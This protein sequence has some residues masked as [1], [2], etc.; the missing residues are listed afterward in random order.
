MYPKNAAS[1]ER[2]AVGA[3]YL[4]ADG[5]IQTTGASVRVMP[6]GGAAGAGTGTLD[7]DATSG[8]W[9]Y[10]PAQSETNYTSFMV[11]VYKASCTSACAT[12]VTTASTTPGTTRVD[13]IT[14]DA[15]TAASINT[16][17]LTADAFADDI[18][19]HGA[20]SDAAADADDFDTD[21]TEATNDHYNDAYILFVDGVLAGQSR[22]IADY[23]GAAKNVIVAIPFTD[24]PG[25]G[26]K[27]VILG[28]SE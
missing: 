12:V 9:H 10:T 8:I 27:F 13:S 18:L 6:Q 22:K 15:I 3:I 11:M 28:R 21:L 16:G 23:D 20:V 24:A 7:V 1:P 4:L 19:I 14:D 2:I 5:T 26:D 25:N 17:A